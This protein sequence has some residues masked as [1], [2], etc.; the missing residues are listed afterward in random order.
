MNNI[1]QDRIP[2]VNVKMPMR[3][4]YE[5]LPDGAILVKVTSDEFPTHEAFYNSGAIRLIL[6]ALEKSVDNGEA[7]DEKVIRIVKHN[8]QHGGEIELDLRRKDGSL[9]PPRIHA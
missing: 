6:Y 4:Q 8:R 3:V 1:T 7:T 9:V 5:A 2:T